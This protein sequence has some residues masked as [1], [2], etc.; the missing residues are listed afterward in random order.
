MKNNGIGIPDDQHGK[1]FAIFRRLHKEEEYPGI[2]LGL[3]ICE[4]IVKQH[5]GTIS[6]AST[7]NEGSVFTFT[8]PM[9]IAMP[10]QKQVAY[11]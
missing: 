8:L 7:A 4:R 11:A 9:E 1:I 6:V 2:G 10:E 5:G 3:A